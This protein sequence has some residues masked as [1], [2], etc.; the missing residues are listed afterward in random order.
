MTTLEILMR[1][2]ALFGA[3]GGCPVRAIGA[4]CGLHGMPYRLPNDHPAIIALARYCGGTRKSIIRYS[5]SHSD[6]EVLALFD[7][8]IAAER[9]AAALAI[10]TERPAA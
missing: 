1:A 9:V 5:D 4:A 7:A 2:R 10:E 6:A 3:D 8:A